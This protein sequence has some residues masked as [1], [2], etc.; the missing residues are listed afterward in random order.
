MGMKM[1]SNFVLIVLCI[2]SANGF[3]F[4]LEKLSRSSGAFGSL[5]GGMSRAKPITEYFTL[6]SNVDEQE[7]EAAKTA[8]EQNLV[9]LACLDMGYW[10]PDII[11]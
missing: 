9:I 5:F 4:N 8:L 11:Q 7:R 6:A 10:F 1:L 2:S 3:K